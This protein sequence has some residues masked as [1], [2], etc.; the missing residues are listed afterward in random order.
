MGSRYD[1]IPGI[2]IEKD[3]ERAKRERGAL[4]RGGPWAPQA[5]KKE[6]KKGERERERETER[7]RGTES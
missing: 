1:H 4:S 3:T 5:P 6:R 7:E 2:H